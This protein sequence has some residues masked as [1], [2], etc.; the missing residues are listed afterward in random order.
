MNS[1]KINQR[2]DSTQHVPW[3]PS[4]NA[5]ASHIL[6]FVFAPNRFAFYGIQL[7]NNAN[8]KTHYGKKNC[9]NVEFEPTQ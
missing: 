3:P 5:N 8:P 2:E 7:I 9:A 1:F 6:S 4:N